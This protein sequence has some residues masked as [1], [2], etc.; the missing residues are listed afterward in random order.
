[1]SAWTPERVALLKRLSAEGRAARAIALALGEG[2]S[3]NAVIGKLHRVNGGGDSKADDFGRTT[4]NPA[5]ERRASGEPEVP[6]Q[7]AE[8]GKERGGASTRIN[9]ADSLPPEPPP[10]AEARMLSLL[11]LN[12]QTCRW[13]IGDPGTA[14]FAFC[15]ASKP[16]GQGVY[17]DYHARL[18][19][20]S[21]EA[22]SEANAYA[23]AAE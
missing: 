2:V 20:A 9:L 13:P 16:A 11:E 8:A 10:P 15:G 19:Y 23:L 6:G 5:N 22:W 17:C 14:D 1:M 12:N 21:P 4:R 3:R 18:A 7:A